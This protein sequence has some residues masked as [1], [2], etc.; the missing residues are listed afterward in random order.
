[1]KA[2]GTTLDLNDDGT[3][4]APESGVQPTTYFVL[5][6]EG[7]MEN[8][9]WRVLADTTIAITE[10]RAFEKAQERSPVILHGSRVRVIRADE[11]VV[12]IKNWEEEVGDN[13]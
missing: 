2:K 4:K 7:D 11:G 13:G 5:Y 10:A 3:L 12:F 1:M 6:R 8:G 9:R